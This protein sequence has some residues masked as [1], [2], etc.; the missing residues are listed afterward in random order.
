MLKNL[1]LYRMGIVNITM[2][3][4]VG[5]LGHKGYLA[6]ALAG[7]PTGITVLIAVL[8]LVLSSSMARRAWKTSKGMNFLKGATEAQLRVPPKGKP[9]TKRMAKIKH[10]R[11]GSTWLA[12]L[13]LIGTMVGFV[14]ALNGLDVGS[15]TE[16]SGVQAMIPQMMTGMKVAL[17]T[18]LAGLG[19]GM[20]NEVNYRMLSTATECLCEDEKA[21]WDV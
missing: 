3:A 21:T 1:L 7:D 16:L 11:D 17:F 18:S 14:M 19:F 20:W 13:G 10:L 5:Y 8:F 2:A 9:W 15:L 4:L 6:M 12:G